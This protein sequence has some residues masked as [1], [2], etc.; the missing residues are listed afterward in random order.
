MHFF[1]KCSSNVALC[2]FVYCLGGY[3]VSGLNGIRQAMVASVFVASYSLIENKKIIKY[4]VLCLILSTVHQ[5]ALVLIPRIYLLNMKAWGEGTWC[6]LATSVLLY[7]GYPLF[8][9]GLTA[10]LSGSSYEQYSY[11]ILN[12]TSGGANILRVLVLLVPILLAFLF[13]DE[14]E[15]N[16]P[17]FN[18]CLNGA[19]LSF[20]FMLVAT[21]R[22]WIFARFCVYFNPFS[23]VLL[24]ESLRFS[25]E[26]KAILTASCVVAYAIF[27]AYEM[28]SIY[29][30]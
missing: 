20:M 9:S 1:R 8:S 13:R 2:F 25:G 4:I 19:V 12:F 22:S 17:Q 21:I 11:G 28:R 26:N 27:F 6:L 23:I 3:F 24:S 29:L 30:F 14:L 16:F 18:I 7:I 5:S 10:L 15:A